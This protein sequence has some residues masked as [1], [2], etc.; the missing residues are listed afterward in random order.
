MAATVNVE[1]HANTPVFLLWSQPL[2]L[3]FQ[4]QLPLDHVEKRDKPAL[5][6]GGPDKGE[7]TPVTALEQQWVP[8]TGASA[9]GKAGRGGSTGKE[10]SVR[11]P[12][13]RGKGEVGSQ[14]SRSRE[15]PRAPGHPCGRPGGNSRH[16]S[17]ATNPSAP[18]AGPQPGRALGF[19]DPTQLAFP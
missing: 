17:L 1:G 3:L 15:D 7:G 9:T 12:W 5:Q 10:A 4:H 6:A 16:W 2:P 13:G 11:A 18:K 14:C 19:A 8:G